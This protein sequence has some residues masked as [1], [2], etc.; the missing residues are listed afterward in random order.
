V[1][2]LVPR[3]LLERIAEGKERGSVDAAAV[4]IDL[5]G[6]TPMSETLAQYGPHGAE[7]VAEI[8]REALVPTVEAVYRHGGFVATFAGDA[9]MALFVGARHDDRALAAARSMAA[10]VVMGFLKMR[11]HS[12]KV[13]LLVMRSERRS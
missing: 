10:A 11:S 2:E 4:Y 8:V 13:R 7:I 12:P 1:R 9:L 5:V 6:F 3:F